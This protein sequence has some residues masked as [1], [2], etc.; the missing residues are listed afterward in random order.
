MA[1]KDFSSNQLVA[2]YKAACENANVAE[3]KNNTVGNNG[4]A[5]GQTFH[6]TGE[7]KPVEVEI[8][9]KKS[10]Y[11]GVMTTEGTA[12]SLK[13]LMNISSMKGYETEGEFINQTREAGKT[14][15]NKVTAEVIEDFNF[16]RVAQPMTRAW[17]EYIAKVDE[18]H[19]FNGKTITFL[20]TVVRPYVAK[21]DSPTTSFES[22][23]KGDQR[24]MSQ[25]LWAIE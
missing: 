12:L 1:E 19:Y 7:V 21:K 8:N 22:Y 14:I 23:K 9:G 11:M 13:G 25:K 3:P 6:C 5:L 24:A 16:D 4:Y 17:L 20:G 2:A 15:D 18:T 10:V